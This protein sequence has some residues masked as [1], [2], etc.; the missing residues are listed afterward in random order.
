MRK[1][2]KYHYIL[3][4]GIDKMN[5]V[6]HPPIENSVVVGEYDVEDNNFLQQFVFDSSQDY[7]D[8]SG[9]DFE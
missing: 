1:D 3:V 6:P 4:T 7:F 2:F 9:N 8:N 5:A